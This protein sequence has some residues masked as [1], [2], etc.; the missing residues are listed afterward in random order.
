[1]PLDFH[2]DYDEMVQTLK[3]KKIQFSDF[4]KLFT[5]IRNAIVHSDYHKRT[6]LAKYPGLYRFY[7]K[8]IGLYHLELLLLNLFGYNG[9]IASRLPMERYAGGNEQYVPWSTLQNNVP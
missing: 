5:L 9:K 1:M 2:Q 6:Q 8:H 7:I 4:P 3:S